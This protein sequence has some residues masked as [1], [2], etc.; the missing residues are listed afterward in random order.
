[1]LGEFTLKGVTYPLTVSLGGSLYAME[2]RS[3]LSICF[4]IPD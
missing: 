3:T 2:W 4:G 1:M